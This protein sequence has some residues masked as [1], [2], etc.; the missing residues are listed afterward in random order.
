V[1]LLW[2]PEATVPFGPDLE[3]EEER[4]RYLAGDPEVSR[5]VFARAKRAVRGW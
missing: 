4:E 3:S 5:R 2:D 1:R